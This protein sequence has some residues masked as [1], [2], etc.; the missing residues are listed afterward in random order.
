MTLGYGTAKN[1]H[2]FTQANNTFPNRER[3][4]SVTAIWTGLNSFTR[5]PISKFFGRSL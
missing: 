4:V 5:C 3:T 2:I 1:G